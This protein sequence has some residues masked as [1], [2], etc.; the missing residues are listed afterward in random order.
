[1]YDITNGLMIFVNKMVILRMVYKCKS[2][3][4][5]LKKAKKKFQEQVYDML[6]TTIQKPR[7]IQSREKDIL[8]DY[9]HIDVKLGENISNT[10]QCRFYCSIRQSRAIASRDEL[11][12]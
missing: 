2:F 3:V 9:E 6:S 5:S 7:A 8:S 4:T 1:M 11:K 10:S 12:V